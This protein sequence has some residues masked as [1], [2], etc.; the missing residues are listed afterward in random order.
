MD[1]LRNAPEG[2]T[3]VRSLSEAIHFLYYFGAD[4]VSLDNDNTLEVEN[5]FYSLAYVIALLPQERRPKAVHVHSGN[6]TAFNK[7]RDILK[8]LD[9]SVTKSNP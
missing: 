9:I 2:W 3:L 7:V 8:N 6:I 1:D 4:E 5:E